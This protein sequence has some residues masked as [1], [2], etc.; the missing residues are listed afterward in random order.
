MVS[1][2]DWVR[3][4]TYWNC[5]ACG[6]EFWQG[7]DGGSGNIHFCPQ[8]PCGMTIV[9]NPFLKKKEF[10]FDYKLTTA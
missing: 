6:F 7:P 10:K 4:I 1:Q 2:N 3:G 5:P 8:N 9:D